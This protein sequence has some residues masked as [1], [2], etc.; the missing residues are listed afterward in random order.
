VNAQNRREEKRFCAE[1]HEQLRAERL[2][3]AGRQGTESTRTTPRRDEFFF[4]GGVSLTPHV[5]NQAGEHA[6]EDHEGLPDTTK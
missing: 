5:T 4:I 2:P 1:I 6:R 3:C